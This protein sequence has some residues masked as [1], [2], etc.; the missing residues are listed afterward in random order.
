MFCDYCSRH[1]VSRPLTTE[2]IKAGWGRVVIAVNTITAAEANFETE[3]R[4]TIR[5]SYC[6]DHRL[7][8]KRELVSRL[9]QF[10]ELAEKS[11]GRP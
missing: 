4:R 2:D 6:P 11:A 1:T 10:D 8:A 3:T 5:L 7:E 9:A